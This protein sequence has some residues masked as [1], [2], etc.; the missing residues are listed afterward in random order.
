MAGTVQN[1]IVIERP[2]E[3]VFDFVTDP[4]TTSLWQP[5]LAQSEI[6]TPGPMQVGT[7]IREVRRIGKAEK[8]AVWEVTEYEPP[9]KRAYV[10]TQSFGPITQSGITIFEA[11]EKGTLVQF[12]AY[13]KTRFPLNLLMPLLVGLMRKQNEKNFAL[14]KQLL[15][16]QAAKP[17]DVA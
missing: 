6:I 2:I 16:S 13:V 7:A 4:T 12:T 11:T 17:V 9:H 14:L 10:Y 3:E 15:E 5:N 1:S 8:S